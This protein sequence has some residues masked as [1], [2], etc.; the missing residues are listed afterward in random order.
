MEKYITLA[1]GVKMPILGLG[2]F[3]A[4]E[5]KSCYEACLEALKIGYRHIDT[6]MGYGN[7]E[8]VGKAI[9]DSGVK[10]EDIFVTTKLYPSKIGYKSAKVNLEES[11]KRLGLDYVD[12]YLIH[13]PSANDKVNIHTWQAFEEL[14]D[15]GLTR[16]IGVSNFNI[17]HLDHLLPNVRIK[18]MI[19]QVELHPYLP[20]F[21][22][23]KYLDDKGICLESYGPFAK[24]MV[25]EDET[26]KKLA[27]KYNKPVANIVTRWG[28]ERNIVMIPKSV[29]LDRIVSNFDV[30]SFSLTKEDIQIIDKLN[31]G[32]RLY[33]DPNNCPFCPMEEYEICD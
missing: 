26:L 32:K 30:F 21:P 9:K 14:Y 6:A 20:Q 31:C 5:G 1:N 10:R 7:E 8:S 22:L 24:G 2:T 23:A 28:I 16:A 19:D 13:W 33:T 29:T 3:K 25:F 12:L 4:S 11:L 15:A 17:N 18:P 27:A